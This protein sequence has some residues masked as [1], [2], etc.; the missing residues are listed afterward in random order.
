[1]LKGLYFFEKRLLDITCSVAG[2]LLLCPLMIPIAIL[3][4]LEDGGPIFYKGERVGRN[5]NLFKMF[6]FRSM[7]VNADKLGPS[8][9]SAEDPR[10][11]RIG[12]FL[13]KYK[14]D[15]LPQ[16]LNVLRGDMSI[17]GPRPEVKY[18]TDMYTEDEM[19][20]LSVKPGITDWASIW[21]CDEGSIL[22]GSRDPDRAYFELIRPTKLALQMKYVKERSF[23]VDLKIILLTLLAVIK[24]EAKIIREIRHCKLPV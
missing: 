4:R 11:T 23:W 3:I 16:L 24:P 21:N 15:E 19:I 7:V 14:L 6:K 10:I 13:R 8:S 12:H 9:T 17:V 20:I 1:M 2:L 18:F 5:G 22:A